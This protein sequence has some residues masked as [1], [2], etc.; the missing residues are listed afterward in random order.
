MGPIS[1]STRT[2]VII[3]P[4]NGRR[5]RVF[6]PIAR[7]LRER[8]FMKIVSSRQRLLT[9]DSEMNVEINVKERRVVV[10]AGKEKGKKGRVIEVRR[11]RK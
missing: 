11:K 3:K 8:R 9:E 4:D 7:E 2:R 10:I 5:T 6:G 1:D